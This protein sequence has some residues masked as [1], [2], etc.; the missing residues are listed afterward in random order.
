M[1]PVK[2]NVHAQQR[3]RP[4][5]KLIAGAIY[6]FGEENIKRYLASGQ[7]PDNPEDYRLCIYDPDEEVY[8]MVSLKDGRS[9]GA[10]YAPCGFETLDYYLHLPNTELTLTVEPGEEEDAE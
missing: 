2:L 6:L 5:Q 8:H 1:F 7:L 9:R 3:K 10:Y 4:S